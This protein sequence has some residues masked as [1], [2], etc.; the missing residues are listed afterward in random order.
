MTSCLWMVDELDSL[1]CHTGLH[2]GFT[3]LPFVFSV[4]PPVDSVPRNE[5]NC[6]Q[7]KTDSDES[8]PPRSPP[9]R[10]LLGAGGG[11]CG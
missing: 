5:G 9:R 1:H 11:R 4:D 3:A 8:A 10:R 6:H 2:R 7:W